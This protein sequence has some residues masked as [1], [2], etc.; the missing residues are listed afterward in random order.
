MVYKLAIFL[1]S[2]RGGGAERA[3]LTLSKSLA[4]QGLN[5]DLVLA[6]AEG[7]FLSQLPAE[8]RLI[9][10]NAS[11]VLLSLP[12][13][14]HY[15]QQERPTALLA[16]MNHANLVALWA[17][18]LSRV[19]TRVIVSVHTILSLAIQNSPHLRRRFIPFLIRH[20]YPWADG[21]VAVS[22]GAADDLAKITDLPR[23]QIQVIYNLVV[24]PDLLSNAQTPI[25]HPWFADGEPPVI[26]GVGRLTRPKDFP[27]LIRA[28]ALV[29]QH[30]PVRLMI[31]GEGEERSQLEGLVREQRLEEAVSLPGFV[32]NPY[33]YMSKAAVF[34]LSS[35]WEGLSMV[36]IEALALGTP[37]VS[38][39]CQSGPRE[40]LEHGKY[41]LLVSVGDEAEMA[42]AIV[43]TLQNPLPAALLKSRAMDF[44]LNKILNQYLELLHY[45]R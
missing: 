13:L 20:S 19:P 24:T 33:A 18:Q 16:A 9:D 6:K 38:T 7:S 35:L 5:V 28:F 40:I 1:P 27:T 15:L 8:V 39:D 45:R 3:I 10:L 11:R 41:G 36:L 25:N 26:L 2:L 31:L 34:V 29:Q 21:I 32:S 4:E 14:I 44:S 17:R 22:K 42:N 37:V 43:K 12:K 23:H 30:C